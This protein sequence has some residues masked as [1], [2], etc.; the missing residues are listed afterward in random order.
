MIEQSFYIPDLYAA[1]G[2][3][4]VKSHRRAQAFAVFN[5]GLKVD[6]HHRALNNH[7]RGMGQRRRPVLAFLERTHPANRALGLIRARLVPA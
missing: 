3:L 7:L 1:L 5:K 2:V 6:P 4:L